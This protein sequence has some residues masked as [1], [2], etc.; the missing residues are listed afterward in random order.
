MFLFVAFPLGLQQSCISKINKSA[1]EINYFQLFILTLSFFLKKT[2]V[3]SL[4]RY[5][6]FGAN[7]PGDRPGKFAR[8]CLTQP[9]LH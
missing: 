7:S 2:S 1:L 5:H 4:L 6:R 3:F 8:P 9:E